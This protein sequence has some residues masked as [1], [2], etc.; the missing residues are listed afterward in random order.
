[1]VWSGK[2]RSGVG[3]TSI[4]GTWEDWDGLSPNGRQYKN[5]VTQETRN[6]S[7]ADYWHTRKADYPRQLPDESKMFLANGKA[8]LAMFAEDD[9][10]TKK[11]TTRKTLTA[12]DKVM[13]ADRAFDKLEELSEQLDTQYLNLEIDDEEYSIARDILDDKMV[14]AWHKVCKVKGWDKE[15]E[16]DYQPIEPAYQQTNHNKNIQLEKPDSFLYDVF[17]GLDDTNL[18]KQMYCKL[19]GI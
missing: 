19:K 9:T 18:F 13:Q 11:K 5:K 6:L 17:N 8:N 1:M 12:Y 15:P 7:G 2:G 10:P 3:D 16:E 14:R 4:Q